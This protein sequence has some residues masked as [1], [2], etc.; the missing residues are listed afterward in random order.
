MLFR[1]LSKILVALKNFGLYNFNRR[2]GTD[3][4]L[5]ALAFH[6]CREVD[7]EKTALKECFVSHDFLTGR[8]Y[9][10]SEEAVQGKKRMRGV[11]GVP[12]TVTL[13]AVLVTFHAG[14]SGVAL[15][16]TRQDYDAYRRREDERGEA[17]RAGASGEVG[18]DAMLWKDLVWAD[19]DDTQGITEEALLVKSS[20]VSAVGNEVP[21]PRTSTWSFCDPSPERFNQGAASTRL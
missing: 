8:V 18:L 14:V 5:T 17:D 3:P 1:L 10:L 19:A 7:W 4:V 13:A 11:D 9:G 16:S 12:T 20:L 2:M 6:L 21:C 15:A